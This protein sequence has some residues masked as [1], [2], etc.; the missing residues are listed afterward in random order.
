MDQAV[1][2]E[3]EGRGTEK[4]Q[5]GVRVRGGGFPGVTPLSLTINRLFIKVIRESQVVTSKKAKK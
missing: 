3:A 5:E 4:E 2:T 1:A